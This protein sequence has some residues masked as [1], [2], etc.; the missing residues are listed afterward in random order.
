MPLDDRIKRVYRNRMLRDRNGFAENGQFARRIQPGLKKPLRTSVE[1]R[2]QAD[3]NDDTREQITTIGVWMLRDEESDIGGV[4]ELFKGDL[5]FR[6]PKFDD[7]GRPFAF[8][9]VII[10]RGQH[11]QKAE[12]QRYELESVGRGF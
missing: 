11:Y 8:T 1:F 6:D 5:Y 7:V 4:A 2:A 3:E 10:E 9:G 12:F